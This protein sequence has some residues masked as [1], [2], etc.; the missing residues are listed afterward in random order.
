MAPTYGMR[1]QGCPAVLYDYRVRDE[2][3]HLK[4]CT[5]SL[6]QKFAANAPAEE[7]LRDTL[8]LKN[9]YENLEQIL[10]AKVRGVSSFARHIGWIEMNIG[11]NCLPCSVGDFKDLVEHDVPAIEATF[12]KW[13]KDPQHLDQ[14]LGVAVT[15]LLMRQENDSA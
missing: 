9:L 14:E 1:R 5:Q 4:E 11:R 10:P 13:C 15:N 12:R 8:T 2:I 6:R 7:I 3:D